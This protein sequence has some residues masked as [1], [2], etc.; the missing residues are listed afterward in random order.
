MHKVRVI[1]CLD[2]ANVKSGCT[3]LFSFCILESVVFSKVSNSTLYL[4]VEY[5]Q[6]F[7]AVSVFGNK[8]LLSLVMITSSEGSTSIRIKQ[9]FL[10]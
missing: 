1:A 2:C 6:T 10:Q 7:K 3:I 9:A 8:F 4:T 5:F